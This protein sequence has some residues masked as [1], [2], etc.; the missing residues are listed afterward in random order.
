MTYDQ[1]IAK[2]VKHCL[3]QRRKEDQLSALFNET[4]MAYAISVLYPYP[5]RGYLQVRREIDDLADK[6]NQ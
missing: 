5:N 3:Q 6:E 1:A 2:A 4:A